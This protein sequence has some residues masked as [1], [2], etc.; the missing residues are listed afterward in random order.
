MDFLIVAHDFTDADA[1]NRR[2]AVR[3]AHLDNARKAR[4]Q[5][6]FIAGGAILDITGK[7]TGSTLYLR[8]PSRKE[9][10]DFLSNDPYVTGKVWDKM[11]IKE[12]RLVDF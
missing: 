5:G 3:Q 6:Q 10:E 11:E 7:M 8:F 9:L 4:E 12:I 1:L 2:L